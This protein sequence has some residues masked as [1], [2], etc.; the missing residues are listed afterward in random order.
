MRIVIVGGGFSGA[1]VAVELLR[2]L[3]PGH[4]IVIYEPTDE[5]GRGIAYAK[6]PEHHLLN[7]PAHMLSVPPDDEGHFRDW[8][9]ARFAQSSR[10]RESDGAYFF[11]RTWFGTY[12]H[13]RYLEAVSAN[14]GVIVTHIREP[15]VSI[16]QVGSALMV[17]AA[18]GVRAFEKVVLAIGSSPSAPF[19]SPGRIE[20]TGPTVAQSGWAF[21]A[22]SI[23]KNSHVAIVGGG[24]TMADV[25]A[26]LEA[27][28]HTGMIT[29]ISRNGRRPHV[30]I[31]IRPDFVPAQSPPE[32]LSARQLVALVREWAAEATLQGLDWRS[33]IDHVRRSMLELWRA[34]Q[35]CERRRLRRHARSLW[36]AHRYLMPP[37]AH[38]RI[39]ALIRS[40][41]FEHLKGRVL[42]ITATGLRIETPDGQR[43][44]HADVI[45]NASG[46]DSS[47][48]TALAPLRDLLSVAQVDLAAAKR[49]GLAVDDQGRLLGGNQDVWGKLYALGFLARAN[50]GDLATVNAIKAVAAGI[51]A[52]IRDGG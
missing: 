25:V 4:S 2:T 45:I 41:R 33:C 51:A 30:A 3:Q 24:L 40:G 47:Y 34:L 43:I 16:S 11:P 26:D 38:H 5:I 10:L 19:E 14:P 6:G 13:E 20:G 37:A 52:A 36:D 15:A 44:V 35:P 32:S 29:C 28:G 18:S 31:G 17:R 48:S 9:L 46:F 23:H 49:D 1:V 21:D 8:V 7:V 22:T 27:S 42:S 12:V 39:E 50:H